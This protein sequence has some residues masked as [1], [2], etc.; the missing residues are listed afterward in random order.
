ML[1]LCLQ[2]PCSL[3]LYIQMFAD[4]GGGA[5]AAEHKAQQH[6]AADNVIPITIPGIIPAPAK[7][8]IKLSNLVSVNIPIS[9][10][11]M[12]ATTYAIPHNQLL[13]F[14]LVT[15]FVDK[16]FIN[17][18]SKKI[19]DFKCQIQRWVIFSRFNGAYSL[20]RNPYCF[21]KIFLVQS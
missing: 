2:F 19:S 1:H 17:S 16:N 5:E 8:N 6:K 4:A 13:F 15:P 12:P 10:N 3:L 11:I 9:K 18:L 14:I 7:P 21:C 20:S